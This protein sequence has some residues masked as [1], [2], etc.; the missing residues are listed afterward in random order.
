M[1][2]EDICLTVA[3]E[4]AEAL[5]M[6]GIDCMSAEVVVDYSHPLHNRLRG[7]LHNPLHID[8]GSHLLVSSHNRPRVSIRS[9]HYVVLGNRRPDP[10]HSVS[11]QDILLRGRLH[12]RSHLRRI[13][14]HRTSLVT[15]QEI[16]PLVRDL[17]KI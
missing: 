12:S 11:R 14:P 16:T 15:S 13:R 10:L 7:V 5:P 17:E 9:H 1:T 4:A 2:E 8:L 3:V 6:G